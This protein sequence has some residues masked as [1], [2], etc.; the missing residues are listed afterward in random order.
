MPKFIT[1][2][3]AVFEKHVLLCVGSKFER[4]CVV[5]SKFNN[6]TAPSH[7]ENYSVCAH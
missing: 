4:C 1:H 6:V 5:A 2:D 3:C 7:L